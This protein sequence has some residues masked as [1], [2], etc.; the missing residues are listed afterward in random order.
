ME[1][2]G[3]KAYKETSEKEKF[4]VNGQS[5]GLRATSLSNYDFFTLYTTLPHNLIKEKTYKFN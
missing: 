5:R 2:S 4:E 1:L 3:T